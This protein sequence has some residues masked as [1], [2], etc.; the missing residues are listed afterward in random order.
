[1]TKDE[2]IAYMAEKSGITKKQATQAFEAF[3]DGV[4][5]QLKKGKKISFSGFGTFTISNLGMFKIDR[6]SAII[7][8]PQVGILAIGQVARRF[9]PGENDQ[10][11][12]RSMMTAT[13]SADHRVVDGLAAARFLNALRDRLEN[14]N[15]MIG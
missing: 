9:V 13:L 5:T 15:L 8:P 14:P 12:A 3:T 10:P 11:V 4:T 1:M 2:M 6:F 7:N